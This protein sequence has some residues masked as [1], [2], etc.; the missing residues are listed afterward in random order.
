MLGPDLNA[1]F[2]SEGLRVSGNQLINIVNQTSDKIW[3]SA[4]RVGSEICS[5][6]HQNGLVRAHTPDFRC[7]TH[8]C[9]ITPDDHNTVF[10]HFELLIYEQQAS[11]NN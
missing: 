8:A 6:K 10:W 3:Y 1:K 4:G 5:L 2:I 7:C 11:S 9:G